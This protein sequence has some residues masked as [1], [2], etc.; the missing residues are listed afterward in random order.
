MASQ[1]AIDRTWRVVA[2]VSRSSASSRIIAADD[3]ARILILTTFGLDE[4]VYEALCAGA[5]GFVL[6][7]DPPEQLITAVHTVA[8]GDALLSPH[9]PSG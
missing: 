2:P 6:K 5:N 9:L 7:D 1:R 3:T 4:Y 8:A